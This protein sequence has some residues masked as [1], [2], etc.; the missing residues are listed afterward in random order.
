MIA[1]KCPKCAADITVDDSRE[2]GFC[3][4]CGAKILL[5]RKQIVVH[6]F[7]ETAKGEL[8]SVKRLIHAELW[9]DAESKLKSILKKY[10]DDVEALLYLAYTSSMAELR[11]GYNST[12]LNTREKAKNFCLERFDKSI[13]TERAR[14]LMGNSIIP[15]YFELQK[16]YQGAVGN[17][18][19]KAEQSTSKFIQD[20]QNNWLL[21][22]GYFYDE[23]ADG[24]DVAFF[25]HDG[26]L[27][28]SCRGSYYSVESVSAGLITLKFVMFG[29]TLHGRM[30]KEMQLKI[31]TYYESFLILP[32]I[33]GFGKIDT[34]SYDVFYKKELEKRK[35]LFV[36][37]L[38]GGARGVLGCKDKCGKDLI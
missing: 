3:S 15:L 21:L 11:I 30:N 25:V 23:E 19:D 8:E 2:F 29:S 22:D 28:L 7:D 13:G 31:D 36:C 9:R 18:F 14:R 4:Y 16:S 5:D 12:Y 37:R 24:H 27:M 26:H 17:Y 20:V 33:G 32:G 10:P 35:S 6:Y 38:C 1:L 34:S